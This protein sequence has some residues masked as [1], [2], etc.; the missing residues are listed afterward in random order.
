MALQSVSLLLC[1]LSFFPF[2]SLSPPPTE[3]TGVAV[4]SPLPSPRELGPSFSHLP[5]P[6]PGP[7]K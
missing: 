1:A 7:Q 2:L 6:S 5:P 3:M 4:P